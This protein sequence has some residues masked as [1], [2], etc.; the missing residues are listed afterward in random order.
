[1]KSH[2]TPRFRR[3]YE[4]LHPTVQAHA[5]RAFRVWVRDPFHPSLQFKHVHPTEPVYSVRIGIHWRAVGVREGDTVWWF[6]IGSHPEY[7]TLIA[8]L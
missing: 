5:R 6:W 1:M 3:A 2:T 4:R 7:E 8:S